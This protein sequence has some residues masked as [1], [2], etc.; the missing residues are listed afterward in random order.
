[1]NLI[2]LSYVMT[3]YNKLPYLKEVMKRLL[4]NVKEDEEIVVVD[5]ASTDGTVEY[6]VELYKQ[7]KINQF[8][9]EPDKGEAHG[10]NKG[11]LMAKGSLIKIITD[12]DAF[13][14]PGIQECKKFMLDHPEIDVVGTNGAGNGQS[15]SPIK[16][17]YTQD[18][19]LWK[20]KKIPFAFCG[21]GLMIRFKSIALVGLCYTGV[22]RVDAEF[23]FRITASPANLAW[24]KEVCWVHIGNSSSNSIKFSELMDVEF[25]RMEQFY[26]GASKPSKIEL[27]NMLILLFNKLFAKLL[28]FIKKSISSLFSLEIEYQNQKEIKQIDFLFSDVIKNSED[29]LELHNN[30]QESN[31]NF[32]LKLL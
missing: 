3:T 26:L 29:W 28:N 14:Y 12:D 32:C 5:G 17:S 22:T 8:I 23:S 25:K 15:R 20:N 9:S 4:E 16:M 7:G 18:Y 11:L 31:E 24:Y 30:K 6:L 10:Y 1:M 27:L 2:N 13:Y 21:L 19:A